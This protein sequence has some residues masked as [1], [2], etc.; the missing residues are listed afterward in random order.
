M[1]LRG[2][3]V[4]AQTLHRRIGA[5]SGQAGHGLRLAINSN[6]RIFIVLIVSEYSE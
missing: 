4:E 2:W 5:L 6:H 3:L 1:R